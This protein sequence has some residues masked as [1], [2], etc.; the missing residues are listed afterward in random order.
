MDTTL[1]WVAVVDDEESIRRAL[2]RLLRSA[3]IPAL[4]FDGADSF[5]AALPAGAPCCALLDIHM[6]RRSG[7]ELQALLADQA[8]QT[9]VII[10]T[11]HHTPE[12]YARAQHYRPLAYLHKPVND[13]QLLA[14]IGAVCP[15]WSLS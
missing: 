10:M 11:G 13:L 5:L 12:E 9:G 15:S 7:L 4:A 2:L 3:G 14:A 1:P 8:P 6:P